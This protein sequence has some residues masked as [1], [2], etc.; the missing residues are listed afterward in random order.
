MAV[1][2][3]FRSIALVLLG[4]LLFWG[5]TLLLSYQAESKGVQPRPVS[6]AVSLSGEELRTIKVFEQNSPS[7]VYI[8]TTERVLDLWTRN[9][10]ERPSGTGTG[11]VWDEAGHIV[12][13]FHVISGHRTAKVRLADQRIL[14]AEV[15]GASPE[16][17]LAVLKLRDSR[18]IPPPVKIG[19]S[20]DLRVGQ[21]V[22]AIG[23]PF[24]LDHTLTTG[25]VSAL[26]RSIDDAD[27][28]MDN[29][30]QTD[31]AINPGNS[32][33]PLLDSSGRVIGVNVAIYSPSGAS[34][35][36]GFA[37]PVDIVNRVIPK[38]VQHGRYVRPIL[39]ITMNDEISRQV[40]ERLNAKGI[41]V[42]RVQP[43][44]PAERAGIQ[45]TQL[46]ATDDLLLG[47]MIQAIDGKAI[48]NSA[49][50]TETLDNYRLNDEVIVRLLRDGR[51]VVEVPVRLTLQR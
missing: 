12:T 20:H 1:R 45:G 33:G 26:D 28:T 21:K 15:V 38:L 51:E 23:N 46:T 34:A 44:S 8:A 22:L 18:N 16:H 50:M 7:V 17:D 40:S 42:L 49:E 37:I 19:S 36:I 32:G 27:T 30:I 9:V 24:G 3:S 10:S 11:F 29:L 6:A 39:G 48:S 5:G 2:Q 13:N 14:E 35:G 41:L 4:G 25:V 43:G 47:D 31:A